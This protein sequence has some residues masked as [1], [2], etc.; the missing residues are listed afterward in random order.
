MPSC[1]CCHVCPANR[2]D[3]PDRWR[4]EDRNDI[5]TDHEDVGWL[6]SDHWKKIF[7]FKSFISA[8]E[9]FDIYDD[10]TSD[11]T[12]QHVHILMKHINLTFKVSLYFE[13][14]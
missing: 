7:F 6:G 13:C 12:F 2:T 14:F 5:S 8:F 10:Y 1:D 11:E 4:S 3:H 9:H